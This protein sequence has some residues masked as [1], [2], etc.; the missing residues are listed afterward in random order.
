MRKEDSAAPARILHLASCIQFPSP[1]ALPAIL[2]DVSRK[3]SGKPASSI[4]TRHPAAFPAYFAEFFNR[5]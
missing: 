1:F 3:N 4:G 2:A 5:R